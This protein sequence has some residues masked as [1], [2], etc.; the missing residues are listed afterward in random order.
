MLRRV[1]FRGKQT[2]RSYLKNKN[3]FFV[4]ATHVKDMKHG[5]KI[6]PDL[7]GSIL[8]PTAPVKE[9]SQ[10]KT[11]NMIRFPKSLKSGFALFGGLDN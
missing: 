3:S 4:I 7:L 2:R 9:E 10:R 1:D 11:M 6:T 5:Q 8:R